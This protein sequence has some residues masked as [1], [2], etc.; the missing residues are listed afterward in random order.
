MILLILDIEVIERATNSIVIINIENSKKLIYWINKQY[1]HDELKCCRQK[2]V[3]F[4]RIGHVCI[5]RIELM[6]TQLLSLP[7]LHAPSLSCR[8][9]FEC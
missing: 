4:T 9:V 1:Y 3:A 8:N 7:L 5:A 2:R 6:F